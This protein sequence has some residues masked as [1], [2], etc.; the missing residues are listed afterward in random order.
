MFSCF[1]FSWIGLLSA[2]VL[3][4]SPVSVRSPDGEVSVSF[5]IRD[6]QLNYQIL[7]EGR[8]LVA[9]SRIEIVTGAKMVMRHHSLETVDRS[10]KPVWGQFSQIRDHHRELTLSLTAGGMPVDLKCRIFDEG[11]GFRF[12]MSDD[13]KGKSL[14]FTNELRLP[15]E[16]GFYIPRGERG[17]DGPLNRRNIRRVSA[18][19]VLERE[20]GSVGAW[21][22]S[23]LYSA[24]GFD[25]MNLQYLPKVRR[26]QASS[27]AVSSGAS[28]VTPWRVT[29]WGDQIGDLMLNPVALNLAAPCALEDTSW[30][31]PGKGLWD[32]RVHG[33]DN[34]DFVYGIDT[35]SYRRFIDSCAELGIEYFTVDDHW[36]T[37][38]KDGKMEISPDVDIEEVMAYAERKGVKIKL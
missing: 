16:D 11:L 27:S 17:V 34:G 5:E 9:P 26:F 23:D 10:W 18:P 2:G 29:L 20:N 13:S 25:A 4:A 28:Q 8:E 15:E 22:E 35:R 30:I 21:I 6:G 32:W 1:T 36:F 14:T 38:A 19:L 12:V 33:Y 3:S 31:Q 37:S 7:E 24:Q